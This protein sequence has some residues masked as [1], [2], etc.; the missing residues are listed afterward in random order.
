MR[1]DEAGMTGRLGLYWINMREPNSLFTT[2]AFRMHNRDLVYVS[3][4]RF[5]EVSKV[6]TAFSGVTGPALSVATAY[7]YLEKKG[8][9]PREV[10][11][12]LTFD[13]NDL[14]RL[15]CF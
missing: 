7:T 11:W 9:R 4:A 10:S 5:T 15:E 12:K 1:G 14:N 13:G 3:N 8:G 6:V 2:Q